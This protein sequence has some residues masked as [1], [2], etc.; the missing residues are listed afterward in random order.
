MP[1]NNQKRI[2]CK[3]FTRLDFNLP[4]DAI[5]LAAFHKNK[6]ITIIEVESWSR[7]L[8]KLPKSILWISECDPIARINLVNYFNKYGVN[9]KRIYFA[10]RMNTVD[11]HLS[12]H[13]CADIFLDTFNYN[14]HSTA[15]D[16][17][18]AELPVVT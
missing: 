7:I 14:A 13:S 10:K 12:R 17:L 9:S 15:I 2:S 11:E 8:D 16:S 1:F 18:W 3:T 5:V 4:N 6:K